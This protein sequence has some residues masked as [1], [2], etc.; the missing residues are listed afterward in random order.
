MYSLSVFLRKVAKS[1]NVRSMLL[2]RYNMLLTRHN[3][4]LTRHNAL[5]TRHNTLS[6]SHNVID[7][8]ATRRKSSPKAQLRDPASKQ[9]PRN[10]P[11]F[12]TS[13]A[14]LHRL[15]CPASDSFAKALESG[16]A[17]SPQAFS[18]APR[19]EKLASKPAFR[20]SNAAFSPPQHA[21]RAR[22]QICAS[23]SLR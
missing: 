16:P 10:S 22:R 7:N 11:H 20:A 5:L 1:C 17:G 6:T 19:P 12:E 21:Y 18:R 2:T 14:R 3:M 15:K 9:R 23:R 4:L 8:V 13:A